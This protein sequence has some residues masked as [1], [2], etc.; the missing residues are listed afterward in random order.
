[1]ESDDTPVTDADL[2]HAPIKMSAHMAM[3]D[4]LMMAYTVEMISIE[5]VVAS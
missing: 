1:M 2:S 4:A 3:V 5:K